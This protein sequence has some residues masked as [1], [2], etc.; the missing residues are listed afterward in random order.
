MG[1]MKSQRQQVQQTFILYTF[2]EVCTAITAVTASET[3][4]RTQY[5]YISDKCWLKMT[6]FWDMAPCS[7]VKVC[8]RFRRAYCLNFL[9]HVLLTGQFCELQFSVA[10]IFYTN[11]N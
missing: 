8:R 7:R 4:R 3:E 9:I 6:V 5:I 10:Y 11:F 2:K 1:D